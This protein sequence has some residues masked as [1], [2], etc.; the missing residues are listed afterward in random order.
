MPFGISVNYHKQLKSLLTLLLPVPGKPFLQKRRRTQTTRGRGRGWEGRG[1][2]GCCV[3]SAILLMKW[4]KPQGK[5]AMDGNFRKRGHGC[6]S[7]PPRSVPQCPPIS[8]VK[9]DWKPQPKTPSFPAP[10]PA[11][12]RLG[13]PPFLQKW[14][15]GDVLLAYL[16]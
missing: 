2:F 9:Y 14:F 15:P 12:G 4:S 10:S 16:P 8:L 3:Q 13:S 5:I 11:P 1:V 6:P 7:F